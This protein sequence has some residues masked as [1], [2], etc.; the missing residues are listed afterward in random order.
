[1]AETLVA[2]PVPMTAMPITTHRELTPAPVVFAV[3]RRLGPQLV[4][5]TLIPTVLCY[6]AVLTVGLAWGVLAAAV[7]T[8]LAIGL[9]VANGRR[10]TGLLVVASAGL[11]VRIGLF[12]LSGSAFIYF[13]QP[14]ARTVAMA[15]L[16]AA[17]ALIR[18][19]LVAR[20]AGDF[21]SFDEGVGER[22]AI[23]ALFRRLTFLWAGGQVVIASVNL[24][25]LLTVPVTVFIGTA[26]GAAWVIIG[27]CLVATVTDA[28]RTTKRDGLHTTLSRGGRLHTLIPTTSTILAADAAMHHQ[29]PE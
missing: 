18:R 7:W 9:R 12:V 17:S 13:L 25:L 20:F 10:V 28:V 22:P 23:T 15:A 29:H 6:V 5:A 11:I 24:T 26:A 19:P 8:A 2:L 1:M 27:I 4:E 21:C 3:M 14:I 16:F